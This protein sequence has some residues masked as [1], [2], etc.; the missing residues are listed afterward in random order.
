MTSTHE[1]EAQLQALRSVHLRF[2]SLAKKFTTVADQLANCEKNLQQLMSTGKLFN[3]KVF[4][5]IGEE[6]VNK[7]SPIEMLSQS[8]TGF[9]D[10]MI[11]N[12]VM[13]FNSDRKILLLEDKV[14]LIKKANSRDTTMTSE[15]SCELGNTTTGGKQ[16]IN[17][18]DGHYVGE[19]MDGL[20]HGYGA[21]YHNSGNYCEGHFVNDKC[22]G[23]GEFF[24]KDGTIYKGHFKDNR[25][26]GRGVV[27]FSNGD[28]Y[29]GEFFNDERHGQGIFYYKDDTRF[30]G[31]FY[32]GKKHG[33]GVRFYSN[34]ERYEGSY[35]DDRRE[36][37]GTYYYTDGTKEARLYEKG[38]LKSQEKLAV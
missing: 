23:Y 12:S 28:I 32:K 25:L 33:L 38:S 20:R 5:R 30:N 17:Y 15:M 4:Q 3:L 9:I 8:I 26:E 7:I 10:N 18:E 1:Q 6:A 14:A 21:F 24:F 34:G 29:E 11:S 37:R 16:R 36:G 27:Y 19:T 35:V 31:H 13:M 2:K 22:N